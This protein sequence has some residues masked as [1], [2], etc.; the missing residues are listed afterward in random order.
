MV[1]CFSF[2]CHLDQFVVQ[3]LTKMFKTVL[4]KTIFIKVLGIIIDFNY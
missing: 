4:K 1:G 3:I 2:R